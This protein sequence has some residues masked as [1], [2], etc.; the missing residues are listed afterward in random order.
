MTGAV[1]LIKREVI[2]AGVRYGSHPI[3]EDAPFCEHAQQLVYGLYVDT[4][5]RP[6]HA[7]EEGVEL[8]AELAGT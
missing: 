3:G 1:Y 6:V 8:V 4:R 2:E 7:Y 5:H